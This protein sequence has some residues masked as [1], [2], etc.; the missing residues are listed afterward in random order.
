MRREVAKASPNRAHSAL[1]S[2]EAKLPTESRLTVIT[3][4]VDGLHTRAGSRRVLELHGTLHETCCTSCDFRR[5]EDIAVTPDLCPQCPRCGAPL[6]PGVVLFGEQ[7][8]A[9]PEWESKRVLRDCDL[10][11]A[12]G[13]SGTVS[14]ASNFVRAAEYA[15]ARTIYVNPE[16]LAP[17]NPAFHETYLGNAED[18]LPTILAS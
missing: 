2:A 13:T 17:A 15:G 3:Q 1:A 14:P 6:R 11:L 12:V 4:N 18:I 9:L 10:F 16:P 5:T 8:P 7:I